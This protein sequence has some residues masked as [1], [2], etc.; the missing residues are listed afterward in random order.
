MGS[1]SVIVARAACLVSLVVLAPTVVHP[2]NR[3]PDFITEQEAYD[4]YATLLPMLW[5]VRTAHA[6]TIILRTETVFRQDCMPRG[7][8]LEEEWRSVADDFRQENARVR[9]LSRKF[10]SMPMFYR[11]VAYSEIQ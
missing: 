11:L 4:V 5:P 10:P 6:K 3:P 1:K 7:A 2:Q 9:K 8:P